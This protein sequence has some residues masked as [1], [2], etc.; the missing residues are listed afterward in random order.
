MR[1][2]R[3]SPQPSTSADKEGESARKTYEISVSLF[4]NRLRHS[5]VAVAMSYSGPDTDSALQEFANKLRLS[6]P[7]FDCAGWKTNVHIDVAYVRALLNQAA[8]EP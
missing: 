3:S 8:T 1:G 5:I 2:N 4:S 7:S 6:L